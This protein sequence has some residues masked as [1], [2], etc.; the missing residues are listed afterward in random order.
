MSA[1]RCDVAI[2]GASIAGC[3]AAT[4]LARQGASVTL[5][6]RQPDPA[7]YKRTCTHLIQASALPTLQRLGVLERL[8]TKGAVPVRPEAWT[9]W[10]WISPPDPT[11]G[12]IPPDI[13]VRRQ[14]LDPIL[15][16]LA[17]STSGVRLMLGH[18]FQRVM[19]ERG[20][21][22][23]VEVSD[24]DR[25]SRTIR[26]RLL[27]G[28]DGRDSHMAA[29][30]G[31]AYSGWRHRRSSF[32]GYFRNV[33]LAGREGRF[34]IWFLNPDFAAAFPTD[35]GLT[36]LACMVTRERLPQFRHDLE[37]NFMAAIRSL[38]EGPG[39][40]Q[41]EL[42][43]KMMGKLEMPNRWRVA[44]RG[45]LALIGDAALASDPVMAVGCGWALQSAEWLADA[46]GAV[47]DRPRELERGL[48]RY[49]A[50]HRNT[51]LPHH[52]LNC[53]YSTGRRFNSIEHLMLSAA[54]RDAR[55]AAHFE[56]F[57]SRT[58]TVGQYA[59]P[60]TLLDVCVTNARHRL[61]AGQPHASHH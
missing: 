38:P 51:L 28:A 10:G 41:A 45:N 48:A 2:V 36:L 35:G 52:F 40:E 54:V 55:M 49:R 3:A 8:Y 33:E 47:L 6:E 24:R 27:V 23:G 46:V 19:H 61:R 1:E 20:R 17:A 16:E 57:G 4:L 9:P 5:I 58:I 50:R 31:R 42:A 44:A 56:A 11:P 22:V 12:T 14:T 53:S 18:S 34:R 25:R 29:C 26:A 59:S 43:S 37:R 32:W 7:A 39:I 60:R 15:R 13:N 21:T 30:I